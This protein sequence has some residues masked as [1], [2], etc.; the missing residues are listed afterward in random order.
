MP[1]NIPKNEIFS[2]A[3]A[4]PSFRTAERI[5]QE[6]KRV[7]M[8]LPAA[9]LN[10]EDRR[11]RFMDAPAGRT[12]AVLGEHHGDIVSLQELYRVLEKM[13]GI[14]KK[15]ILFIVEDGKGFSLAET[16]E[17]LMRKTGREVTN[18]A[19]GAMFTAEEIANKAGIPVLKIIPT[20]SNMDVMRMAAAQI[21]KTYPQ[22]T[23]EDVVAFQILIDYLNSLHHLP[24][25][26][27]RKDTDDDVF[28]GCVRTRSEQSGIDA[29]H[30]S[31]RANTGRT[32][33]QILA[34]CRGGEP[35][36]RNLY[37]GRE[38]SD[39]GDALTVS[40]VT[41]ALQTHTHARFVAIFSGSD[42]T[43]SIMKGVRKKLS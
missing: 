31:Q 23:F 9:D 29:I 41:D 28:R 1:D 18:V 43:P 8:S 40:N 4:M 35:I 42:H 39:A 3:E 20:S 17:K 22:I 12:I 27:M 6:L 30:L 26:H 36:F 19:P 7:G 13:V 5:L 32:E 38:I 11:V 10:D 15:K 14:N 37:A 34:R 25:A 33:I 24:P 21:A 2:L 16:E